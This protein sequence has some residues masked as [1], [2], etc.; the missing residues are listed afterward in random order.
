MKILMRKLD[1]IRGYNLIEVLIAMAILSV[2][3]LG[4]GGLIHITV[5]VNRNSAGKTVA[6]TLAQDKMEEMIATG[7]PHL[8]STSQTLT[9]SYGAMAGYPSYRR[10]SD[11]RINKPDT[12][13]K[14]IT[15]D[16]YWND[17]K[18][19]VRLQSL[20]SDTNPDLP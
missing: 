9:E 20:L 19:R 11:I 3:S 1:N 18:Q 6:V 8:S 5:G 12:D 13:I 2:V 4:M 7:Y 17:D 15:V 16:V 14:L 10:V